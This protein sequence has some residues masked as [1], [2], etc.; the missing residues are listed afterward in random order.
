MVLKTYQAESRAWASVIF[1]REY[2]TVR[3]SVA[4]FQ[5]AVAVGGK[6][7]A[8]IKASDVMIDTDE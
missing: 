5:S 6:V 7:H 3:R 8:V 2:P 4:H 1:R